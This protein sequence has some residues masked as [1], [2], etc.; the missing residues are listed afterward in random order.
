MIQSGIDCEW[1]DELIPEWCQKMDSPERLKNRCPRE[2]RYKR[3]DKT[4][5][6][7]NETPNEP[8]CDG[9]KAWEV[10][11]VNGVKD[12]NAVRWIRRGS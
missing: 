4:R 1:S 7:P 3:P 2:A 11:F 9:V 12:D 8:G 6:K 10:T 5:D